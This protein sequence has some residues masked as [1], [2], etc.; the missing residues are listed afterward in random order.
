MGVTKNERAGARTSCREV[1]VPCEM[2]GAV[3]QALTGHWL[4][5][6]FMAHL[7]DF[8]GYGLFFHFSG[9]IGLTCGNPINSSWRSNNIPWQAGTGGIPLDSN[10]NDT[11]W[12]QGW[13]SDGNL[14]SF[15]GNGRRLSWM[16]LPDFPMKSW[17]FRTNH[18]PLP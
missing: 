14:Q 1:Q 12:P 10:T 15:H 5:L 2:M 17:E 3:P 4:I 7:W 13:T 18:V 16:I 11:R 9:R 6:I 8:T